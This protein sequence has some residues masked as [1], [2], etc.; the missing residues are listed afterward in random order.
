MVAE[1]QIRHKVGLGGATYLVVALLMAAMAAYILFVPVDATD[2]ERTTAVSWAD[3]NSANP[4]VAEYLTREARLL[5]IGFLGVS[6]LAAAVAWETFHRDKGGRSLALWVFPMT[7][8]G[9]GIVFLSEDGTAIGSTYLAAGG[10][11]VAGL[12]T[13]GRRRRSG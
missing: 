6:L 3:F 4:D 10:V 9:A 8:I 1:T 13:A 2:F 11:A 12:L 7:L 5:A